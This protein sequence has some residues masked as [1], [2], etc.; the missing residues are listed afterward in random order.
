MI[1]AEPFE[2]RLVAARPLSPFVREL[3]FERTDARAFH[4]QPGQWVNLVLP[5][6]SG[7]VKR[8]YSIASAPDGSPRFDLAVTRVE[9]GA[10]SELL[11]QLAPGA[12]LRAIGPHGLFTR[13]P[14]DPAPSLFVA[15][16]TGVTPLRSMLH[17]SLRAGAA[18]HLWIL[19]GA[20]FEEDIIY[21]EELEAL[22][23]SSD[24]IR[25]EITLSRGAPAWPGRRGYVQAHVPALYRELAA[26]SGDP[27]PHVFICGLD[28]M[29]SSVRELARNE[30]GVPRKHVHVER[31]D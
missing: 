31:Y 22:A 4:F 29:V 5:L 6:P 3:S 28:R 15:T 17:A 10:G 30:L 25:Y 21:R 24:R 20:R 7:E 12:T 2:A 14:G 27:A 19:F 8:A 16:G 9:G 18:P 1:H 11:H 26:A 13:D 23:R